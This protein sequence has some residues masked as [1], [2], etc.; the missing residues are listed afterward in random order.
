LRRASVLDPL[1]LEIRV[2]A[3]FP[4]NMGRRY[5]ETIVA[6]ERL[7]ETN[8]ES[9]NAWLVLGQALLQKRDYGRALPALRRVTEL[10]AG[11]VPGRCALAAGLAT[12][13]N[14]AQALE[15]LEDVLAQPDETRMYS[16]SIAWVHAALGNADAALHWL[17]TAADRRSEAALFIQSDPL[18]DRLRTDA[19]FQA[20]LDRYNFPKRE[21]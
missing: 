17:A 2:M 3:L 12:A 16:Y 10:N 19:R 8:P 18:L 6:A 7:L 9:W 20:I 15:I 13:G 4:L 1:S 14:R 5:D 21:A 11:W